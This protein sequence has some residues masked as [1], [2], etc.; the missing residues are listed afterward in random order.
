[1]PRDFF[2]SIFLGRYVFF[3]FDQ[4]LIFTHVFLSFDRVAPSLFF[5]TDLGAL[6][7]Q[8]KEISAPTSSVNI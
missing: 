1:M 8:L 5:S 4:P 3:L 2:Y 6:E 7:T